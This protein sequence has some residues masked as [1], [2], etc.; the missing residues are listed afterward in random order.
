[1]RN[2]TAAVAAVVVAGVAISAVM[3]G[4]GRRAE[5]P[6]ATPPAAAQTAAPSAVPAPPTAKD[7]TAEAKPAGVPK[8][9]TAKECSAACTKK[10]NDM[11]MAGSCPESMCKPG[12]CPMMSE[13]PHA[14]EASESPHAAPSKS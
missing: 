2:V 11:G 4:P 12:V 3:F 14:G 1:M 5:A 13:G 7:A 8:A 10:M 9:M 6:A